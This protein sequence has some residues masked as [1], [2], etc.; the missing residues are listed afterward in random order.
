MLAT[1]SQGVQPVGLRPGRLDLRIVRGDDFQIRL[2]FS[3]ADGDPIDVT[4]WTLGAKM[5]TTYQG[6]LLATFSFD[7][8]A[9]PASEVNLRL[10][11]AATATLGEGVF[12]WDLQ[13]FAGGALVRTLLTGVVVVSPDVTEAP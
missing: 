10:D 9:L 13:R 12:P 6:P 8:T 4:G 2:D 3:T 1:S 7:A 5:R 11:A